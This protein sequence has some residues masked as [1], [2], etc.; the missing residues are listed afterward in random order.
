MRLRTRVALAVLGATTIALVLAGLVARQAV[1][2]EFSTVVDAEIE[3]ADLAL[4]DD[5]LA[6]N[7]NFDGIGPTLVELDRDYG[8]R[9]ILTD[10][11][12]NVVSDSRPVD[13]VP[14]LAT[15]AA[16]QFFDADGD[17]GDDW[18]LFTVAIE[19]ST[20]DNT[21]ANLDRSFL[22]AGLGSLVIAGLVAMWLAGLITGPIRGLT[23][24]VTRMGAGEKG[25]RAPVDGPG[26]IG[27]LAGSFNELADDLER[28]EDARQSMLADAS[29]ELRTPL[30]NL[31]GHLEGILDGVVEPDAETVSGLVRDV[32]RL[33]GLVD[34][35]QA[36][37][38]AEANAIKLKF[39]P[40]SPAALLRRTAAAHSARAQ[41][42]G[43]ELLVVARDDLP[44]VLVDQLRI[45][46]V[47]GNLVSNAMRYGSEVTLDARL[48]DDDSSAT[49][50]S[51][52][53]MVALAVSDD[54]PGIPPDQLE[55]VFER[56]HRVD[57]SRDRATGGGG[58]GLAIVSQLVRL[59][60]GS[61]SADSNH[62]QNGESRT[63]STFT[64]RLPVSGSG[65][66]ESGKTGR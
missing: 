4:L 6:A 58:L 57:S 50:D 1:R 29:H 10:F 13:I 7:G 22:L 61:V 42:Q 56:F 14:P 32:D 8:L 55:Q 9:F 39:E 11:N 59:H 40:S 49:S 41:S 45:D 20:T 53:K 21:L 30:A 54:G 33:G 17:V 19:Q 62:G 65:Q 28:S 60:G 51:T 43:V 27:T 16:Y 26:E 24:T 38:L 12:E 3:D 47:L 23:D 63:G 36:L 2:T 64:V 5:W 37:S 15:L 31:K 46:Q 66:T 44:D 52:Q 34:D 25:V 48:I 35:L 18:L